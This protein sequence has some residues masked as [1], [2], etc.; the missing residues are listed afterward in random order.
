MS[1]TGSYHQ[2]NRFFKS[3]VVP[4][5]A[6]KKRIV[7]ITD[8]QLASSTAAQGT[9]EIGKVTGDNVLKADFVASTFQFLD[10]PPP[11]PAGAPK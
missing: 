8:L 4:E 10:R 3:L 7:N 2:I 5:G 9:A 11:A 6:E 1:V